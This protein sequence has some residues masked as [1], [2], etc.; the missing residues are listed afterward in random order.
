MKGTGQQ[1]MNSRGANDLGDGER[2]DIPGGEF[3]EFHPEGQIPD[4]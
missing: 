1:K 4:G 2:A 3:A